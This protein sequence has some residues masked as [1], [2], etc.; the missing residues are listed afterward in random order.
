MS[1]I[2]IFS[3]RDFDFASP[4]EYSNQ[5]NQIISNLGIFRQENNTVNSIAL[6]K[7]TDVK[8]LV[9]KEKSPYAQSDW[10]SAELQDFS[11][12]LYQL[13][14]T[15]SLNSV[16]S[17]DLEQYRRKGV[18]DQNEQIAFAIN[19]FS[20]AQY[21]QVSNIVEQDLIA[22]LL[23]LR[24]T[25]EYAGQGDLDFLAGNTKTTFAMDTSAT[26]N[27]FQQLSEINRIQNI[28]LGEGLAKQKRGVIVLAAGKAAVDLRYHQSVKD[29]LVYTLS[30]NNADN[31]FTAI[32]TD[33]PALESWQLNG[34]TIIDVSGIT[35]ITDKIGVDGFVAIP[36]MAPESN[37]FVLHSGIGVRHAV[38]GREPGL[39][40]QYI[41][42]DQKFGWPT[43]ITEC[44]Y[45]PIVNI[46]E[47]IVFG[48]VT[49]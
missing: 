11:S 25:S 1:Y 34:V 18:M 10:N 47:A 28:K 13:K 14:Y 40:H 6:D 44:S 26:A 27:V 43:C 15:N 5:L 12:Y 49:H 3:G 7:I 38:Q 20:I 35:T 29:F 48:A 42:V 46:P 30:V 23:D 45:L 9:A 24:V 22:A 19:D 36:V 4:F 2:D 39:Y 8:N 32:K 31:F 41:L 17:R 33:N 16:T 21:S 37:A